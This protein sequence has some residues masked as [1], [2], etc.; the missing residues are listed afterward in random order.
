MKPPYLQKLESSA[1]PR[2]ER[3]VVKLVC[4]LNFW[5]RR[6]IRQ[7]NRPLNDGAMI[8]ISAYRHVIHQAENDH[9]SEH[10]T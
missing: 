3:V 4:S 5:S 1:W 9:A 2:K 7:E 8:Y 6:L 10:H